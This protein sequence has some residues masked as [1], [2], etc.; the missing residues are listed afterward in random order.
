MEIR[1]LIGNTP[2]VKIKIEYKGKIK[3]IYVKLEN[4]NYTGSIKDRIAYYI[5]NKSSKAVN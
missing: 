1:N 3:N 4:Y 5:I 2:I